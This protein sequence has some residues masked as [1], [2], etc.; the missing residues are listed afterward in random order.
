MIYSYISAI[1]SLLVFCLVYVKLI[2]PFIEKE[3]ADKI[4]KH[5]YKILGSTILLIILILGSPVRLES[6][7]STGKTNFSAKKVAVVEKNKGVQDPLNQDFRT[8]GELIKQQQQETE[9]EIN[10]QNPN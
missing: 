9:N 3:T 1:L 7:T 8:K 6:T 5:K 4:T 2:K 10:E